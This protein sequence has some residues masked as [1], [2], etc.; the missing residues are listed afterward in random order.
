MFTTNVAPR[1]FQ[2]YGVSSEIL[3]EIPFLLGEKFILKVHKRLA[4]TL[5]MF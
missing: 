3:R 5:I 2:Q 1:Q 4:V